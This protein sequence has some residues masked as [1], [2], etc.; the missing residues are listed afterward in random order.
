[1]QGRPAKRGLSFDFPPDEGG[2][3]LRRGCE[4]LSPSLAGRLLRERERL[5]CRLALDAIQCRE[6]HRPSPVTGT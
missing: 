3:L 2:M 1:M 4:L 5:L 6:L